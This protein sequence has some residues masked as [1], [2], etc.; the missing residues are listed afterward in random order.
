MWETIGLLNHCDGKV[1]TQAACVVE[2][3]AAVLGNMSACGRDITE[4]V[5]KTVTNCDSHCIWIFNKVVT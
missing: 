2:V 5:C 1:N 4:L 3:I